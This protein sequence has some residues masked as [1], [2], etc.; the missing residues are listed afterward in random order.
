MQFPTRPWMLR[1]VLRVF[2]LLSGLTVLA[3]PRPPLPPWPEIAL[4]RW[5][6]DEAYSVAANKS[7]SAT[8]LDATVWAESWSGYALNRQGRHVQPV[9]LPLQSAGAWP[10]LAGDQGTI[11]F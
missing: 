7:P 9:L 2:F 11:R 8:T 6:F 4:F 10:V 5:S 1:P 3:A